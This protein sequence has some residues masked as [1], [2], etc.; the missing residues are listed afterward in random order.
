MRPERHQAR[1]ARVIC[2]LVLALVLAPVC[3]PR[4]AAA[5]EQSEPEVPAAGPEYLRAKILE[6]GELVEEDL[7][8]GMIV[9]TQEVK[10]AVTSGP[11]KGLTLTINHSNPDNVAFQIPVA[12]GRHVL[13]SAFFDGTEVA[14]A[15]IED[16][17][18][19]RYLLWLGLGFLGCLLLVG[20]RKGLRA[21]LT[22]GL[23]ILGVLKVLLPGLLAG[24]SPIALS[25]LV[26]AGATTITLVA[27]SGFRA[28]T[29]AAII[30]T[31]GG[32]VT[33]GVLARYVGT[34]AQL[35]GY[36]AEE[37]QMLLYIPQGIQFD[38]RGLL[39]AGMLIGALGAV[40]DVG[41]SVA[42]AIDEIWRANPALSAQRL[43]RS[44]M[45][46]GRDVMGTMSNTLVLAYTGGAIPLLLLFMA[47]DLPL[48]RVL[49]LDLVATEV[50]RALTGSIGLV[51]AIPITA[52]AG[53]LLVSMQRG[54]GRHGQAAAAEA[55]GEAQ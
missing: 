12:V 17:V 13:V 45:N 8:Y 7:G 43:F 35:T 52:A 37:A 28:K 42:S 29:L 2:L 4:D 21:G 11:R 6:V 36:S 5:T 15:Y 1:L 49:N 20:G 33:A 14:E 16:I 34:L 41:M 31:T 22:L 10:M 3:L 30:G 32:V 53:G 24:R 19:D 47:Y 44:G 26:A 51:L 50:V 46:V 39:F 9:Y 38:F 54:R 27:V 25:V 40:M 18:R 55:A 23:T 48:A